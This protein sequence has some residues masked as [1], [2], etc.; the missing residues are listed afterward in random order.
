MYKIIL[1]SGSPRRKEIMD[2]M[3]IVYQAVVGDVEETAEETQP[4]EIVQEL[5]GLKARA[6]RDKL[7]AEAGRRCNL[8]II[9]ADTL[10]FYKGQP[11]GK[12]KD[13]ADAQRMLQ[14]LCDDV[15]E[16]YTG[17]HISILD[18]NGKEEVVSFAACTKVYVQPMTAAQIRDY[19]ASGEPMDKAGAYAIQGQFGLYIKEIIG[20]YYNVVGFPISR[21]YYSLL[22][23]GID[24]K[25]LN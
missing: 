16:V 18:E 23:K 4:V 11:L 3:G 1:A 21:I 24:I 15:H 25:K 22:E 14:L 5:A 6:V 8:I 13:K 12:P 10:V 17:I 7:A 19:I 2:A 9:G 20:D